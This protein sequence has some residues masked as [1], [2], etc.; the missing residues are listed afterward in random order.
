MESE[1][2]KKKPYSA[3]VLTKLTLEQAKK[4]V[5]DRKNCSAEQAAQFLNS[6][7]QTPTTDCINQNGERSA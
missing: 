4:H 5:A 6:L 2:Q 1:D 7:R 3:P